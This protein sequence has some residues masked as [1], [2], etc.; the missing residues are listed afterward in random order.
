MIV[1]GFGLGKRTGCFAI[2]LSWL[3]EIAPIGPRHDFCRYLPPLTKPLNLLGTAWLHAQHI[4]RP[5]LFAEVKI[6]L[7]S[8]FPRVYAWNWVPSDL[9]RAQDGVVQTCIAHH[10]DDR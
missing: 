5:E 9:E 1:I 2:T 10:E 6:Q 4:L 8:I 7:L 3:N